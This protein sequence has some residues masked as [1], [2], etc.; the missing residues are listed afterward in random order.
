M[1]TTASTSARASQTP[2]K[3]PAKAAHKS[4]SLLSREETTNLVL[5][6]QEAF[7]YQLASGNLAPATNPNDWRRDQV[8]AAVGKAGVS[9][10]SRPEWRAVKAHFLI[11]SGREDEAF[12]ILNKTGTKSYRPTEDADTWETCEDYA[13]LVRGAL[14]D[15]RSAAA[16]HP[17]G[18]IHEGW[19][20]AA[21]RQRSGIPSLTMATLAERLDP[22]TLHGM[23]AHLRSH[24]A[25]REGRAKPERR[26]KRTYLPKPNPA[27][28]HEDSPDPF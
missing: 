18:H 21:A 12:E 8:M 28:M 15:H 2:R 5:Q 1:K 19:F 13:S 6:A 17:K 27:Q 22:R 4:A 10:I 3:P 24:I 16:P 26:K 11:L 14:A 7:H 9:K 20:L 25:I 23:L